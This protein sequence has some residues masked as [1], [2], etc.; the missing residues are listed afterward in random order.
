M[1]GLQV[2]LLPAAVAAEANAPMDALDSCAATT[3]G[4]ARVRHQQIVHVVLVV[5][6]QQGRGG[7]SGAGESMWGPLSHPCHH[8]GPGPCACACLTLSW[9]QG[10]G[11]VRD[12]QHVHLH[13]AVH[14]RG[15]TET[16]AAVEGAVVGVASG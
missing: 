9:A 15:A 14:F 8:Q 10:G 7:Q 13:L 12:P 5:R 2:W 4:I 1:H 16:E 3:H 11:D 6:I